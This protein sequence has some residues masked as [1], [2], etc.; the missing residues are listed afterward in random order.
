M[1]LCDGNYGL[2]AYMAW[3][4]CIIGNPSEYKATKMVWLAHNLQLDSTMK[5]AIHE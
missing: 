4:R 1:I 5:G 2:G 3:T